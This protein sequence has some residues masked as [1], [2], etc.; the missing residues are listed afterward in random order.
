MSRESLYVEGE[1]YLSL[2]TLAEIYEVK[3][4]WLQEVC[5]RR[6]IGRV[7]ARDRCV[8][9]AAVELDRVAT[10]VRLHVG[11]GLELVEIVQELRE[12]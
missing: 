7:V 12:E 4:V 10:I 8:W 1:L 2:E 9:I 5:D 3:T 11:L 6:L